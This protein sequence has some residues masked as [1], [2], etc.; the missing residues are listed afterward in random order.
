MHAYTDG[1]PVLFLLLK[2]WHYHKSSTHIHAGT[3]WDLNLE[4]LEWEASAQQLSYTYIKII[5]CA[6]NGFN[7]RLMIQVLLKFLKLLV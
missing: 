6:W 5:E 7:K 4:P 1:T 3:G 2:M